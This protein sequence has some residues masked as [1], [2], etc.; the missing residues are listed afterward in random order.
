[1]EQD[2]QN[3]TEELAKAYGIVFGDDQGIKVLDDIL[4][5]CHVLDS[6]FVSDPHAMAYDQGKRQV[7]LDILR[8]LNFDIG[9][10]RKRVEEMSNGN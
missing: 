9:K 1:M 6:K 7:A 8:I 4:R 2:I 3:K 5:K 10:F